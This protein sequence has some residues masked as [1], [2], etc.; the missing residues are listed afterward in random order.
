MDLVQQQ[1][2]HFHHQAQVVQV[3]HSVVVHQVP[4]PSRPQAAVVLRHRAAPAVVLLL[5]LIALFHLQLQVLL[6]PALYLHYSFHL[7]QQ[8]SIT[9][10]M[11]KME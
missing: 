10:G 6:G 4:A 1:V 9:K 11:Q 2:V 5:V 8:Y 7:M 3:R